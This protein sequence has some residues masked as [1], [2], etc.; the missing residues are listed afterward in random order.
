MF[1]AYLCIERQHPQSE[2]NCVLQFHCVDTDQVLI[3]FQ[4]IVSCLAKLVQFPDQT[5][6]TNMQKL[7]AGNQAVDTQ[8]W[9][10]SS[11]TS[12]HTLYP[13]G[14]KIFLH[15]LHYLMNHQQGG[16]YHF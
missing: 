7:H 3:Q 8:L 6:M 15:V 13:T 1:F 5:G 11:P 12:H 10:H 9:H 14:H 16:L 4:Y 2:Y